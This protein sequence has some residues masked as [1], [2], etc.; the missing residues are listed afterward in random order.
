MIF[1]QC[2]SNLATDVY[3]KVHTHT[4]LT[5]TKRDRGD[6]YRQKICKAD[7]PN[8]E[9]ANLFNY[10]FTN[11]GPN[12]VKDKLYTSPLSDLLVAIQ[13]KLINFL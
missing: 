8:N 2:F 9:I 4:D 6:E 11:I 7:L 10:I 1:S 13:N 5:H 12:L 3:A